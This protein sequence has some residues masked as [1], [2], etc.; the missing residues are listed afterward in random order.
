MKKY[1]GIIFK[2]LLKFLPFVL[3][4]TL[5]IFMSLGI[6]FGE[7]IKFENSDSEN[8]TFQVGITGDT[9]NRYF[10]LGKAALETFDSSRFSIKITVMSEKEAK[11]SLQK[12]NISA[13][14]VI[15]E[16]FIEDALYGKIK[17]LKYV[18]TNGSVGVVSI[19]KD[20]VT[21]SIEE[22]LIQSQKGV[23]GLDGTMTNHGYK[24]TGKYLDELNIEYV[25]L[26]INRSNMYRVSEMGISD[27]L[28]M[29]EYIFF[30]VIILFL[31]L[32]GLPYAAVFIKRDYSLNKL[33][34][35]KSTGTLKQISGEYIAYL[36]VNFFTAVVVMCAVIAILPYAGVSGVTE[37]IMLAK[38]V[39]LIIGLFCIMAMTSAFSIMIFELTKDI[40]SGV[41]M[42]FFLTVSLCYI[43]GC[44]YPIYT[45]PK[46][47]QRI[48]PFLPTGMARALLAD[49]VLG[50][51]V[52]SHI[53]G[54]CVYMV[55]FIGITMY[56]RK[57]KICDRG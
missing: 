17:P 12:G 11:A 51:S 2:K 28:S 35:S 24:D 42:H 8:Q 25:E 33:L 53:L 47:I 15:P 40:I 9:D 27:G 5:V 43:S 29:F 16:G 31:L 10:S 45:F 38:P 4:I 49:C 37:I 55:I 46:I 44:L 20:E 18:S 3:C 21:R 50:K 14:V 34:A 39:V 54:L 48:S 52:A 6:I 23:Y 26:I 57:N 13:Y 19:F 56:I 7:I 22:L 1:F 36:L 41:L 30:G 32:S